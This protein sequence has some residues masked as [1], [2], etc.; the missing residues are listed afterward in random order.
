MSY[1]A[2][3]ENGIVTEVI[4]AEQDFINSGA[5]G[6]PSSWVQTS[7]NTR[8][9]IHYGPDGKPDEGIALRANY[10]SS[11]FIY[12]ATNDV[13]YQPQPF[14]SWIISAPTWNWQAPVP[15][16]NDGK[17]YRWDETTLTWILVN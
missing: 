17:R 14:P 10:A 8:G 6:D 16:P 13:F 9:G 4:S 3:V 1:F 2:K 11:G 7:Y 15:H 12:D 5:V